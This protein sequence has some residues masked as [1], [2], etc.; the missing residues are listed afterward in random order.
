MRTDNDHYFCKGAHGL[1][2]LLMCVVLSICFCSGEVNSASS[3]TQDLDFAAFRQALRDSHEAKAAS[4]GS[5]IL[6]RL[7]QKYR[8]DPSFRTYKSKLDTS[9][10]LATQLI[11]YLH[12]A[13]IKAGEAANYVFAEQTTDNSRALQSIAPA[14]SFYETS[15]QL[16]STPIALAELPEQERSFLAQYY[17][18]RLRILTTKV[19]K[20]GQGLAVAEPDFKGTYDYVLVLPLLHASAQKPFRIDVL[21]RWMQTPEQ[22]AALSDSCLLHF[23]FPFHAM[24]LA[25]QA[26]RAREKPFLETEFYKSAAR[27]CGAAKVHIGVDCL[28]RALD[29]VGT[30][31]PNATADLKFAIVQ[32]WLD[33]EN[34]SLAAGEAREIFESYPDHE[35]AGHAIWLHYYALS[36]ASKTDEILSHID[37]ALADIRCEPHKPRLMYV[38]WWALRRRRDNTAALAALEYEFITNYSSDPIIA[39]ILLAQVV[40]MLARDDSKG[41]YESI[42]QIIEKFPSTRAGVQARRLL[43]KLK[44]NGQ[45]R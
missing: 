43:A 44:T 30:K 20:A 1:M 28:R 27:R 21:P 37:D 3:G 10:F 19:A 33:S 12:K 17:D 11:S 24:T 32:L 41:A 42:T 16:F 25:E 2:S 26:A 22:L 8:S 35:Q 18:L 13:A 7:E 4:T 40:D 34:Y 38:K 23:G 5:S 15:V 45:K 6:A 31:D 14:K 36:R 29:R 39:P 9:E